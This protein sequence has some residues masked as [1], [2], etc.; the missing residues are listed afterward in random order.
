VP[1]AGTAREDI[2]QKW[3]EICGNKVKASCSSL[4]SK[5]N[6]I[7]LSRGRRECKHC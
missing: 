5:I 6:T 7:T 1:F 2:D 4:L 3:S